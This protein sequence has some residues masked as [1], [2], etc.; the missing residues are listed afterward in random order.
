MRGGLGKMRL[1]LEKVKNAGEKK[2]PSGR[3]TGLGRGLSWQALL[4]SAETS[5]HGT[6]A[7]RG[8]TQ[9]E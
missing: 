8:N 9:R 2:L 3:G 1:L 7:E 6:A 4:P 5:S